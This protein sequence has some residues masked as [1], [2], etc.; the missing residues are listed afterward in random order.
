[1]EG[2]V[3]LGRGSLPVENGQVQGVALSFKVTLSVGKTD[4]TLHYT[5]ELLEEV[6]HLVQKTREA[7]RQL[8]ARRL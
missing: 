6:L 1:M 2:T 4:L 8:T 7:T 3:V 5:G